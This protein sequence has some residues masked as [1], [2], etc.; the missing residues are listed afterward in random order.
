MKITE[1]M[2]Y[3]HAGRAEELW[4]STFPSDDELPEHKFSKGFE[5]KMKK[6]LRVQRRSPSL[7]RFISITK[8]VAVIALAVLTVSFSCLMCV[9]AYREKFLKVITEVFEDLSLF[10]FSSSWRANPE[11]GEVEYGYLPE[12]VS[13]IGREYAPEIHNQIIYFEDLRGR[14]LEISQNIMVS[15]NTSTFIV[16]TEN[17]EV[18]TI[19]FN[20]YDATLIIKGIH[21]TLLWEDDVSVIMVSGDF[22]SDEILKVANE[23]RI[24]EK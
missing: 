3:K 24:L 23:I 6:L 15:G 21:T 12:G 11:L 7:N 9:E 13:E 18:S 17:A 8:R 22:P 2:L 19:N 14:S 20:G 10:S 1:E 5:R 16:D 4:L